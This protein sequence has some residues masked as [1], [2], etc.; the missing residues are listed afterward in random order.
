MVKIAVM[1]HG[2][3][4]SGVAELLQKNAAHIAAKAGEEVVLERVLDLREF[5]D[6]PYAD[7]FT[8][9]FADISD[10]P[11]IQIV[12]ETMGGLTPA[13]DYVKACLLSGKSV[14]TSNK[15]LVAQKG[16]ELLA[17]AKEKVSTSSLRQ[18]SAAASPCCA[19]STSALP[20]TR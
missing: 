15:E 13:Y 16:D 5:P 19:R 12:V 2:V 17:I 18:A 7:K 8:K 1:G 3:V 9:R 6:L 10:D 4:G 14:V 20:P 11:T